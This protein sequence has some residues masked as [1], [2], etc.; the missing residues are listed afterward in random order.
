MSFV[1][2]T[3]NF[4]FCTTHTADYEAR[5]RTEKQEIKKKVEDKVST[6]KLATVNYNEVKQ[7]KLAS[8]FEERNKKLRE[9]K[10]RR[11]NF[12]ESIE[13]KQE[14]LIEEEKQRLIKAVK[15]R[16]ENIQMS[17]TAERQIKWAFL[18]ALMNRVA[19][20]GKVLDKQ[21]RIKNAQ[22]KEERLV[23]FVYMR[24]EPLIKARR[25]KR[26]KEAWDVFQKYWTFYRMWLGIKQK[27]EATNLIKTFLQQTS[28]S[29]EFVRHA[30]LFRSKST[31]CLYY[32]LQITK[33]Y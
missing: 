12:A 14:A 32:Y 6:N 27:K 18:V 29:F 3:H 13:R 11:A 31:Y 28:T 33:N 25:S 10:L 1:L 22:D 21:R 19:I 4:K 15:H 20:V 24:L 9:A 7:S 8:D 17:L 23:N 2:T 16:E 26:W 30:Q 5:H